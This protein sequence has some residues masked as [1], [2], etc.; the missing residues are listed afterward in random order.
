MRFG[1]LSENNKDAIATALE[2]LEALL[3]VSPQLA[4]DD[5]HAK[6]LKY[7]RSGVLR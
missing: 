5:T 6:W 3:A 4:K 1:T 2:G 7:L